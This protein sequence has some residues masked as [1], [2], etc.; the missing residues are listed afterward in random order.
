MRKN[1]ISMVLFLSFAIVTSAQAVQVIVSVA[2]QSGD[3]WQTAEV[4]FIGVGSV[5]NGAIIDIPEGT[6]QANVSPLGGAF[7]HPIRRTDS[8]IQVLSSTTELKFE[9]IAA[10]GTWD[11]VDQFSESWTTA[12]IH[13]AGVNFPKPNFRMPIND[14]SVYPTIFCQ[15][16]DP[17]SG[18]YQTDVSV[19]G[20]AFN[21]H[22]FSWQ[23]TRPIGEFTV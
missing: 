13:M 4:Q 3:A 22:D 9:W 8:N 7:N 18:G 17:T 11:V 6:Y 21:H 2:D 14:K 16:C 12:E 20:G 1:I 19:L 23:P 5:L 15:L 10:K